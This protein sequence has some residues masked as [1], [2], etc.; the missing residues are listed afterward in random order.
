V[1]SVAGCEGG[2]VIERKYLCTC[3][4]TRPPKTDDLVQVTT[5]YRTKVYEYRPSVKCPGCG[6][7]AVLTR[8]EREECKL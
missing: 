2:V 3:G 5:E 4:H 6:G 8:N 7:V 1:A